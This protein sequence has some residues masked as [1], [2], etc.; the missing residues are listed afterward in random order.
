MQNIA[1]LRL[2]HVWLV[3]MLEKIFS[4]SKSLLHCFYLQTN[5]P[6]EH[7]YIQQLHT[8]LKNQQ[9]SKVSERQKKNG[10]KKWAKHKFQGRKLNQL[11]AKLLLQKS[12]KER[13][14]IEV[15]R[16]SISFLLTIV[17]Q[18]SFYHLINLINFLSF[19]PIWSIGH[20]K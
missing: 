17:Q 20:Q 8:P 7:W 1:K 12:P 18:N 10:H 13:K 15:K 11:L 6:L 9:N 4:L 2:S 19:D 3:S 5:N 14:K 16:I